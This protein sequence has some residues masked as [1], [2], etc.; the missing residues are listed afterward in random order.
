MVLQLHHDCQAR[1]VWTHPSVTVA[2]SQ[3][4]LMYYI[5]ENRV[6]CV[7]GTIYCTN[8]KM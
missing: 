3:L 2:S 7:T 1:L 8:C 5:T 6:S 4:K